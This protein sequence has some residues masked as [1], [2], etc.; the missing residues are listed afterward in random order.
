LYVILIGVLLVAGIL[1]FV[2]RRRPPA[3]RRVLARLASLPADDESEATA[4]R[5]RALYQRLKREV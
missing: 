1:S 4:R 3:H 5:R 2:L